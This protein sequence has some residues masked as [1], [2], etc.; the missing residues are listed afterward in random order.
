VAYVP[1]KPIIFDESIFY[2]LTYG[3]EAIKKDAPCQEEA[4]HQSDLEC[5]Q[6]LLTS[7]RLKA[8]LFCHLSKA[9]AEQN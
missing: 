2:N 3:W 5:L 1:Q 6:R 4:L 7:V 9:R 8:R